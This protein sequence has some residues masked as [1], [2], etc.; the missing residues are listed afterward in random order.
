VTAGTALAKPVSMHDP[1]SVLVK[2]QGFTV[3][4]HRADVNASLN[5]IA[6]F[7]V[8]A[9][10]T[11]CSSAGSSSVHAIGTV[12]DVPVTFQNGS[13]TLAGTLFLP[14]DG[15]RHPAVVLFHGSGP[16]ARN[17]FM[18][19]WFAEHG[20]AAL[21]YDKRGVNESTGDFRA[22]SFTDLSADGLAA[23]ALLKA[24]ADINPKRIGVWGL[25]QGGW[26]GPLAASQSND[27]AFV[28][29]VSGP[30]VSPGE[31]MIFYYGNQL[32]AR[33]F[34]ERDVDEAGD[35]RRKVWHLLS[36]GEGYDEARSALDRARPQRWFDAVNDQSDGLFGRPTNA[37]LNDPTLR[38]RPWYRLEVNYDPT[39][40]LRSLTVPALFI[41]GEKDAL[42]PVDQSIAIIRGTMTGAGHRT[43]SIVVFPGADHQ[44]SVSADGNRTLAP[45]YLDT[46]E[47]WLRRTLN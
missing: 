21:A 3:G 28:V 46:I 20:V 22:V 35:L 17:S 2:Q 47:N 1:V 40:A 18:G 13:V 37:L 43:F 30:G 31:Q 36:T 19:R 44:I 39:I 9:A 33:G 16:E 10:C 12:R 42:V 29:A 14:D 26:L 41:F 6:A 24:R 27:V 7:V 38:D 25:S 4:V 45:G 11:G 23:V 5:L 34:S 32:R 8:T 15:H